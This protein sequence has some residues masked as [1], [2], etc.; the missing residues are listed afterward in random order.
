MKKSVWCSKRVRFSLFLLLLIFGLFFSLTVSCKVERT[1]GTSTGRPGQTPVSIPELMQE[2]FDPNGEPSLT[3]NYY[4]IFDGSGSMD[5]LLN[6]TRKIEGAKRAVK[7]FLEQVPK[8]VNLGLYVFSRNRSGEIVTLGPDNHETFQQMVESIIAG[9][10]TPLGVAIKFGADRLREQ[11]RKQLGYG[12]YGLIVV[13]DGAASDMN[14]MK[15]SLE[16]TVQRQITIHAIG[17]GV[18]N[19]HDLN[20]SRYVVSYTAADDFKQLTD[21]LVDAVAESEFFDPTVFKK[22]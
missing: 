2:E 18:G 4:V 3:R 6:R 16:Y 20:D 21:A 7:T 11:R 8:D 9:G 14:K 15:S 13:T 1:P 5:D 22:K 10:N 12:E 19:N 17:L